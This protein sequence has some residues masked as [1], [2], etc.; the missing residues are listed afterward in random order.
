MSEHD[1]VALFKKYGLVCVL[2]VFG[3]YHAFRPED[4]EDKQVKEGASPVQIVSGFTLDDLPVELVEQHLVQLLAYDKPAEPFDT[5][6]K[7]VILPREEKRLPE[8]NGWDIQELR[9]ML[10]I[11]RPDN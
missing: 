7:Y 8:W 4:I 5:S 1:L 11:D 2:V 3:H 9:K 10:G 6:Q